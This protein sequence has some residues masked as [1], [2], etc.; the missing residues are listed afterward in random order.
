MTIFSLDFHV[1]FTAKITSHTLIFRSRRRPISWNSKSFFLFVVD[2]FVRFCQKLH[3]VDDSWVFRL[4]SILRCKRL[5]THPKL[6]PHFFFSPS[7]FVPS[8]S[9]VFPNFFQA[10]PQLFFTNISPAIHQLF[11]N[12]SPTC[13]QPFTNFSLTFH[14]LFT[15][16]SPIFY[17]L[18]PN[19]VPSFC[20]FANFFASFFANFF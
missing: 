2:T 4:W 3:I 15:N 5:L 19:L 11:T 18:C 20:F 10:F 7:K 9:Q 8:F 12:L 13:H 16:F 6:F 1:Y 14:Q 17:Q